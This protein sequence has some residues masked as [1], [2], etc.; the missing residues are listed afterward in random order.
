MRIVYYGRRI[1]S[2][3][4]AGLFLSL[5][6]FILAAESARG[7][8]SFVIQWE[9]PS[10]KLPWLGK[11]DVRAFDANLALKVVPLSQ[12]SPGY[13]NGVRAH[14]TKKGSEPAWIQVR[15][16][17]GYGFLFSDKMLDEHPYLWV[18]DMGIYISRLGTWTDTAGQRAAAA[19][20]VTESLTKPFVSCAEKYFQWTGYVEHRTKLDD[21]IWDFVKEKERWPVE[22]R[23]VQ[24]ISQ[25]PEVDV[26]YF[27]SRFPDLKYS[28]MY[29]GWPDHNDEFILWNNGKIGVSS[30]S[31]GG[32]SK[33]FP[34]EPWQP[35]AA[36]YT[37]QFGVGDSPRYREY[38]DGNVHQ[39]L[40]DGFHLIAT[41]EWSEPQLQVKQTSFAYPLDGEEIKTGV[42]P[43]LAWT[44]LLVSNP[45]AEDR[46]TYLGVEFTNEDFAGSIPLPNF[47]DLTW[48]RGGFY[49]LGKLVA[50]IDPILQ[51]EAVPTTE[52]RKRF[53]ALV[54]LPASSTQHFTFAAFYRPVSPERIKDVSALGYD[55]A[56]QRTLNFWNKL[57]AQGTAIRV[58]EELFN[59]LYRTFL[60]RITINSDLDLN[61]LS[62]FQTGPI[63]YNRVWHHITANAVADY[64]ARRGY[65]ELAKRYLEPIFRWQGMPAPDSP[66]IQD[67]S[68]FFGAPPQQ[69]PLVWLMYQGMVQWA[70]ARYFEL[71]NDRNWLDEKLPALLKSMD[72]VKSVRRQTKR[73]NADGTKPLGYG[74]FPPGRVTDGSHGTSIFSDANIWRGM[75]FMTRV[76]ETIGH[77]RAAEF[78]G[79]TDDYRQC[80]QDGMRRAAAERPL[81]RLNDDTWVPYLPGY[82][83]TMPGQIEPTRWY[84]AVVD[85]PWEGGLLDTQLFPPG[86]PENDW[87]VNFFEDTYSPMNPSL[88]DEPQWACHASEYLARDHVSNFL[89]TLYSHSTT[90]LARETLTTYEHRSGGID[91]VY[92]LTGWAA[93]YWTRNFT[94]MLCRTV[95]EDL[96]LMQATPRRWL[97]DGKKVEVSRLQTEF[98]PIS[99]SVDSDIGS[100]GIQA[101]ITMPQRRVPRNVRIRFRVPESRKI[102]SV[103]VNSV[104]WLDYDAAGE[105][106]VL[107][108]SLKEAAIEVRY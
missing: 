31:V 64:L 94:S 69:C 86:S 8:D 100:G 103:T 88:P 27:T 62:V 50:V 67:W 63:I 77:P 3:S 38:G 5:C 23:A 21:K 95:G 108:G 29:L 41:T 68:G 16:S 9:N 57:D 44:Q 28:R 35:R 107:P 34:D 11:V 102:K 37:V 47:G 54:N 36:G 17:N 75:D 45:K 46:R 26:E 106:I 81:V 51:F 79:E 76:L 4:V 43:L 97:E 105:W 18:R 65:F 92:E 30:R 33:R 91:R 66:A 19:A 59:N 15:L 2:I 72:W 78:R 7:A 73:M 98:G 22:A 39:H 82:L 96:W 10:S 93:G 90:T 87:L 104:K 32:D 80:L 83:E 89:Y 70:S 20:L 25:L 52:G 71:S 42:E 49:L 84:A 61:G 55:A 101:K 12:I 85:G 48:R 40:Q 60:P 24:H 13:P 6:L 56:L 58:P 99:F 1:L 14:L 53:R 74:W